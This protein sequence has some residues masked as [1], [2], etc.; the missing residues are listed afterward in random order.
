VTDPDVLGGRLAIAGHRIGVM[1]VAT[2]IQQGMTPS[3]IADL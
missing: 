3:A 1:H 2:W